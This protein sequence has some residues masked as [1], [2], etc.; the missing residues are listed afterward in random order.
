MYTFIHSFTETKVKERLRKIIDSSLS[1]LAYSSS[2]YM[3]QRSNLSL[4]DSEKTIL[5]TNNKPTKC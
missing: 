2:Q 3:K 1:Q 5:E 4:L